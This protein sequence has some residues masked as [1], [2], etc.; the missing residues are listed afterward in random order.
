MVVQIDER[1]VKDIASNYPRYRE[2]S[3]YVKKNWKEIQKMYGGKY[4]GVV[5]GGKLIIADE[6][7]N[8]V[9]EELKR[10]GKDKEAY[11]EYVKKKDEVWILQA[12]S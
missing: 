7:A 4:I 3:E 1:A 6:D 11:F 12:Y 8:K 9:L 10:L 5:D 2:N